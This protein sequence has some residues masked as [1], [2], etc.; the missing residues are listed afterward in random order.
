ML[1][2]FRAYHGLLIGFVTLIKH[3]L[4]NISS[5]SFWHLQ[6]SWPW[7]MNRLPHFSLLYEAFWPVRSLVITFLWVLVIGSLNLR[8][9]VS[10]WIIIEFANSLMVKP[11]SIQ[12]GWLRTIS[13]LLRRPEFAA[14]M[15]QNDKFKY[16]QK[17]V[18][19]SEQVKRWGFWSWKS[20]NRLKL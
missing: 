13:H 12:V 3:L 1:P 9:C 15:Q 7:W 11:L 20:W 19:P 10:I 16:H 8:S 14:T 17:P 2:L 5:S 18:V 6:D 4:W